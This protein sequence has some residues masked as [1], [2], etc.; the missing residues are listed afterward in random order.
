MVLLVRDSFEDDFLSPRITT[1]NFQRF[2]T[3]YFNFT[4]D[5]QKKCIK[6]IV[7]LITAQT[8]SNLTELQVLK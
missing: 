3:I 2:L 7:L 1:Q 4:H 8:G 5:L 6:F